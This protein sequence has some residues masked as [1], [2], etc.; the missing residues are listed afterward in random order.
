MNNFEI[1]T[2]LK[3]KNEGGGHK[4][5]VINPALRLVD[6]EGTVLKEYTAEQVEN[7]TV[8][9]IPSS[10]NNTVDRDLLT[11]QNYNRSLNDVKSWITAHKNQCLTIGVIYTTIDGQDHNYW[12]NPR[13]NTTET[14]SKQ[15]KATIS[16]ETDAFKSCSSLKNINIPEGV[17]SIGNSAFTSCSSLT[18]INIPEGVTSIGNSAFYMCSSLTNINI[19]EGVTSIGNS[20]FYMCSSLTNINIPEGVTSIGD[21]AFNSCYSLTSVNIPKGVTSIG[22]SAFSSCRSLVDVVVQGKPSLSN[23]DVF[24]NTYEDLRIYVPRV[25]LTWYSTAT[26]WNVFYDD[27]VIV[28]IE[29]YIEYLNSIGIDVSGFEEE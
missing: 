4:P 17:T 13:L 11:F 14:I 6:W 20:A 24:N 2:Y 21:N 9:P 7:L 15:K 27:N 29:D 5:T 12:N 23:V 3:A 22:S 1:Y 26:N 28:A 8:F 10:L 19:P 16:V 18:N 25:Y